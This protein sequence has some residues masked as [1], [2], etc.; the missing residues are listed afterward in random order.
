MIHV[1]NHVIV[2]GTLTE[3]HILNEIPSN[4]HAESLSLKRWIRMQWERKCYMGLKYN[5][6][7][8]LQQDKAPLKQR[9]ERIAYLYV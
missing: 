8:C 9:I 6:N 3:K 1:I 2:G 5:E 7:Y 4:G